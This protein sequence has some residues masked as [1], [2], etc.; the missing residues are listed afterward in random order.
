MS[1]EVS[2]EE[3]PVKARQIAIREMAKLQARIKQNAA[4]E[5]K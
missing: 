2:L 3:A 4:D 1:G 5:C